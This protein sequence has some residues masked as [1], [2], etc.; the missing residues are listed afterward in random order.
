MQTLN[1]SKALVIKSILIA[2]GLA[3]AAASASATDAPQGLIADSSNTAAGT[4]VT[5]SESVAQAKWRELMVRNP[6]PAPGCFHASYPNTVWERVDCK[7]G[8]PRVR[9]THV[10]PPTVDPPS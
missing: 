9:P 6:A 3:A 2:A 7:I 5:D 8:Q 4:H 10:K 1:L